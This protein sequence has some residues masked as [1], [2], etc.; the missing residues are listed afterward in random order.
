MAP[1]MKRNKLMYTATQGGFACVVKRDWNKHA[2][3]NPGLAKEGGILNCIM[4]KYETMLN[5][6]F[7][8]PSIQLI[9]VTLYLWDCSPTHLY[10]VEMWF[11][12]S[13]ATSWA[14]MDK[15]FI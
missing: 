4:D 15:A 3:G 2:E 5:T 6:K 1:F 8:T 14:L 9:P 12:G 13:T 11:D 10:C 7:H